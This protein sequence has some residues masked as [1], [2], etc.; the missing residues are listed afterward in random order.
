MSNYAKLY[1]LRTA[2]ARSTAAGHHFSITKTQEKKDS[3][4][5]KLVSFSVR[6]LCEKLLDWFL[7]AE[8]IL[9]YTEKG[10]GDGDP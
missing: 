7:V 1:R 5:F 2:F 6:E 3:H 9:F 4:S 10:F 8:D